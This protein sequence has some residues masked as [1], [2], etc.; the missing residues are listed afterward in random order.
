MDILR[1]IEL[2]QIN[3]KLLNNALIT[4]IEQGKVNCQDVEN[5]WHWLDVDGLT[6]CEILDRLPH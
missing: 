4:L 5:A 2:R 1:N 6:V 3:I